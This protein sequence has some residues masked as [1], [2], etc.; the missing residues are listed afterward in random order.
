VDVRTVIA[1][2]TDHRMNMIAAI[3]FPDFDW[4]SPKR[5]FS[6]AGDFGRRA[7]N[8]CKVGLST[9]FG[10]RASLREHG[11]TRVLL[12]FLR[13]PVYPGGVYNR[14]FQMEQL[15]LTIGGMGCGGCVRHVSAAL[16]SIP[17]VSVANVGIGRAELS[18]E[19]SQTSPQVIAAALAKAGYAV[20]AAAAPDAT[21]AGA[22]KRSCH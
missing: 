8:R 3:P 5:F 1:T 20:N 15:N 22:A 11:I 12:D 19:P 13:Q 21:P 4:S 6:L 14:R 16:N 17:G 2:I 18:Y 10:L 9:H 7:P